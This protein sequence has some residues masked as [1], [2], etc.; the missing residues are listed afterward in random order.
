MPLDLGND[1]AWL[2]PGRSPAAEAGMIPAHLVRGTPDQALEQIADP[3]LQHLI[4]RK[5]DRILD[6]LGFEELVDIGIGKSSIGAD[7][8]ARDL[9]AIARHDR[10]QHVP[11]AVRAVDVTGTQ[12][13]AFQVTELVEHKQWMIAGAFV[14]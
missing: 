8:E 11:P 3:L 2:V 10:R 4:G 5:A 7:V 6:S 14:M 13:R 1:T 9:A 12:R